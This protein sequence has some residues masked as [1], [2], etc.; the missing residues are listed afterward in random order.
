MI[1]RI[2]KRKSGIYDCF[3]EETCKWLFTRNSPD[4][5]INEI[6][7]YSPCKIQFRDETIL[8]KDKSCV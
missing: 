5:V 2:I 6:T 7:K 3:D 8:R 1:I 4:N